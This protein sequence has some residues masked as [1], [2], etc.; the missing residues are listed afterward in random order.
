MR[1][2]GARVMV[3]EV[4]PICALQAADQWT[5]LGLVCKEIKRKGLPCKGIR[6]R[7]LPCQEIRQT[8]LSCKEMSGGGVRVDTVLAASRGS[9]GSASAD[10]ESALV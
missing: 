4:D 10:D 8:G 5:D 2:A 9:A 3:T 6:Q 1:G 7:G